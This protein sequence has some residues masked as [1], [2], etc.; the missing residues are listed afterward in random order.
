MCRYSSLGANTFFTVLTYHFN[1]Q[2]VGKAFGT[3]LDLGIRSFAGVALW[4]SRWE[5]LDIETTFR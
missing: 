4:T 1:Y 5:A 2:E 3:E